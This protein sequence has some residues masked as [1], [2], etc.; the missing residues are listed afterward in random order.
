MALAETYEELYI[1]F[2]T[3]TPKNVWRAVY[4]YLMPCGIT[5]LYLEDEFRIVKVSNGEVIQSFNNG[6]QALEFAIKIR[7][8]NL[9]SDK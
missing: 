9:L 4:D 1:L 8:R 3:A 7:N 6:A 5:I 2:E